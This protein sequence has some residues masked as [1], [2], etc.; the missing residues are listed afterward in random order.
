MGNPGAVT[1]N[2]DALVE[3]GA[4]SFRSAFCQNPVCT[5]SRCSFMSGWYPHVAG[6]RTMGHMM[7]SERG[8][9]T[10]LKQLKETDITFGGEVKRPHSRP[11]RPHE[12]LPHPL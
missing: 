4:M 2:L 9:P 6:H 11:G 10:L 3:D 12:P 1:P 8:Q 7:H 5:P